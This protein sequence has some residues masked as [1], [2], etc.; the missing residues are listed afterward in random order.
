MNSTLFFRELRSNAP[1]LLIWT[2]VITALTSLTMSFYGIFL[3]NN[4]KILAMISI[5]PE[6]TLQF[7]GISD[8]N[9]LFSVLG[10][11]SANNVIYMLVLGSIYSIVL[12]SGILLREEYGKTAEFL[13]CLA[14]DTRRV[15][16]SKAAV[17]LLNVLVINIVTALAGYITLETVKREPFS[18]NAFL[19]MS[20]YTLL[21]NLFFASLGLFMSTLV[22]R[23]RPITTL[24][25]GLVLILYF[26]FTI[27]NITD[28]PF[29]Y[30]YVSPYKF[31]RLDTL[32]P[33]YSIEFIS[34]LYFIGLSIL[35]TI[36][37]FRLYRRKDIY[38]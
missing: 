2:A 34:V 13:A 10:F 17:V 11:Y 33:H 6:G 19:V 20:V 7:K 15:F 23:A 29:R 3:E 25:I 1:S 22:K 9:D 4:Q 37:S 36:I 8:V 30:G 14:P 26:I 32:D 16:F 28:R 24:S 12:S 5:L 35:L 31:A 18:I 27:S 21:L 38:L